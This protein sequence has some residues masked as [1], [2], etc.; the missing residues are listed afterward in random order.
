MKGLDVAS[1]PERERMAIYQE[2][3][4]EVLLGLAAR[5]LAGK[6]ESIDHLSLAPEGISPLLMSLLTA[7]RKKLEGEA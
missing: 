2:L 5:E 4:A 3:P 7:G 6:L 1:M